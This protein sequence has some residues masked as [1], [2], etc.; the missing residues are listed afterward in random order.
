MPPRKKR[1]ALEPPAAE[2]PAEEQA[3][4]LRAPS[5]RELPTAPERCTAEGKGLEECIVKR[6]AFFTIFAHN[7]DGVRKDVGGDA[8]FIAIRGASRVRAKVTDMRDGTYECEWTPTN[9]GDYTI[10]VSLFGVSLPGSPFPVNVT[11]P[12]P[13]AP[14][15]EARGEALTHVTA[16]TSQFFEV[17]FRDRLGYSSQAVDLDVFVQPFHDDMSAHDNEIDMDPRETESADVQDEHPRSPSRNASP[18]GSR[19]GSMNKGKSMG[20]Q[21]SIDPSSPM[22][23]LLLG[24]EV[25]DQESVDD[26]FI[27]RQQWSRRSGATGAYSSRRRTINIQV[28]K[29]PL[30][31]REGFEMDSPII[32]QL[33]AGQL[34]TV[35][36]E[37]VDENGN[38]RACVTIEEQLPN[39]FE[40][41]RGELA[42]SPRLGAHSIVPVPNGSKLS[43]LREDEVLQEDLGL[44]P[45]AG[46]PAPPTVIGRGWVTLVKE[47][48]KLVTSRVRLHSGQRQQ[49]MHQWNRRLLNDKLQNA[50]RSELESDPTGIGFAFGGVYP[51]VIHAKGVLHEAHKV[52]FSVG[53][54]GRYLLHVRLRQHAL[55]IPGSPFILQVAPGEP[56]ASSTRLPILKDGAPLRGTVGSGPDAGCELIVSTADKM[57]NVCIEGGANLKAHCDLEEV[58]VTVN[59][60]KDGTYQLVWKSS[61]SG[62][63]E[64]KV[65]INGESVIGSPARIKLVSTTPELSKSTLFGKCLSKAVAGQESIFHISFVDLYGNHAVP[66]PEF[67]FGLALLKD[68]EKLAQADEHA[69]EGRWVTLETAKALEVKPEVEG[70]FYELTYVATA[71]GAHELHVWCDP[72][73][74][75]ERIPFPGSPFQLAV[76]PGIASPE[77]SNVDG[78]TKESRGVDKHGKVIQTDTTKIIAGD[79]IFLKPQILDQFGN[80]AALPEGWLEVTLQMPDGM[81]MPLQYTPS[82]KGGVTTY[83]VRY[84]CVQR[85]SYSINV[86]L[87]GTSIKGSPVEFQVLPAHAEPSMCK[88]VMP[89]EKV[90]Y[91]NKTATV[92]LETYDKFANPGDSGGLPIA[93][94]LQLQKQGVHDQT[95]L[96]PNNHTL[97]TVDN[98]DGTYQVNVTMIKIAAIVKLIVNMDK[99]LPA[100]GGELPAVMLT[101]IKDDEQGGAPVPAP[102]SAAAEPATAPAPQEL[103]KA[104]KQL[105][106]GGEMVIEQIKAAGPKHKKSVTLMAADM[107]AEGSSTFN[108]GSGVKTYVEEGDGFLS[109]TQPSTA[110]KIP[111]KKKKSS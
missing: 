5:P 67:R 47:G 68:K 58:E 99:N 59:D 82:V 76:Q 4:P 41:A 77:V 36:E 104:N 51:G 17:L 56:S 107:F 38:V 91:S 6:P 32:G 16:R 103:S 87:R 30:I 78:W 62:L 109:E 13:Y 14:N 80:T 40:S 100:A 81:T 79:N 29:K 63:F 64:S 83:D 98:G 19:S 42:R 55:P 28:G 66:T 111:P 71:A 26:D 3:K 73:D 18:T 90:L 86:S 110:S 1:A 12:Y 2:A 44:S 7:T 70:E 21:E 101:F 106:K 60:R 72:K 10:A 15:C 89:Q 92:I 22:R 75:G 97:E 43:S 57:G 69:F 34:A 88:L 46:A 33:V 74:N 94:R 8:F 102:D 65:T 96:M 31:V 52:H 61:K 45:Q 53:L 54:V 85:G 37:R 50:V 35:I 48:K 25:D 23:N 84:E 95:M 105:K 20:D 27:R 93:A 9:S 24:D 108:F 49:H 11:L 39:G